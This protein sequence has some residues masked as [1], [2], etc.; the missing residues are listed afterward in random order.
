MGWSAANYCRCTNDIILG[1]IH[2]SGLVINGGSSQGCVNGANMVG[3]NSG[4]K[5]KILAI[6]R[7]AFCTESDCHN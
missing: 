6:I 4:V 1:E 7:R 2:S 3:M 5:T